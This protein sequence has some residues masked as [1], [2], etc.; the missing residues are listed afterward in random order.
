[1]S[2]VAYIICSVLSF[3]PAIVLHEMAHGFAA[4]KLGDPTA[5]AA[6]RLS[7][8]PM[9]HVDVFGTVLLPAMLMIANM[10]VFG[11]AKPVPYNPSYFKDPRKGDLIVGLAGP[12]ANLAQ[13][14]LAAVV[15]WVLLPVAEAASANTVFL[16]FYFLFLPLFALINLY[17]MFFNL[18]PI[19]LGRVEHLRVLHAE[20]IL[21]AVLP[22]P[23][24]CAAHLLRHR[25]SATL[26]GQLQRV[27][28]LSRCDGGQSGESA[29]SVSD[30]LGRHMA[31]WRVRIESFEGPFDLLLY[32]VSKQKVDIGAI[33]IAQITDQYLREVARMER[34]DLDVASDFL[35]VASTLLAIKAESLLPQEELESDDEWDELAPSQARDILVERLVLYKQ[36]KNA[37]A[38]L[39]ARLQLQERM[40]ERRFGPAAEIPQVQP[41]YLRNVTLEGLGRKAA[42]VLARRDTAL[43]ESEHIAA[44]P[45]PLEVQIRCIHERIRVQ[46]SL[47]FSE[48]AGANAPAALKVVTFLALLELYKR[49]LVDLEQTEAFGDIA[50]RYV[51]GSGELLLEG[52]DAVTS[53]REE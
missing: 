35:L 3:V 19:P 41:D 53:S 29:V 12:A 51:E 5:K 1:M 38:G 39:R 4:Y 52:D 43:L 36:Y 20:E 2:Q 18:L 50:V 25:D 31:G 11:Y 9:R 16:Y 30:Q 45:L 26:C 49:A 7:F 46:R 6:G 14:V 32:L 10:P 48:L 34:L 37:A 17:L 13:A 22:H 42:A 44:K 8:N 27:R 23:T 28:H 15:A 24:V 33:P 21:A 40:H 47:R